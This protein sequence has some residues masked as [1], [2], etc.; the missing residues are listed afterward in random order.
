MNS[1]T[2]ELPYSDLLD[3][4]G[5]SGAILHRD[6]IYT[7]GPPSPVVCEPI[8]EFVDSHVGAS[9]LDVGCGIGPYL[10]ALV[11][12]GR[13]GIGI[14]LDQEQV[15]LARALG[16][17]ARRMSAEQLAFPDDSFDS[18]VMIEVLEHLPNPETALGEIARVTRRNLVMTVPDISCLPL[19]SQRGV[20]PWHVLEGTHV[21]F[22]TPQSLRSTLLRYFDRCEVTQLLPFMEIDGVSAFTHIAAVASGPHRD[23]R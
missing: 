20:S 5:A 3:R 7:S 18:V 14:E 9:F 22:F 1:Q 6:D 17:D 10:A 23:R 12:T 8:F 16:R 2:H 13:E 21:N 4:A 19:M 15:E 11:E